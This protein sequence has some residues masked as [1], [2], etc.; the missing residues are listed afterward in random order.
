MSESIAKPSPLTSAQELKSFFNVFDERF[1]DYKKIPAYQAFVRDLMAGL[2]VALVAIP[3]GVGFSIASGMR[4]EQGIIAG[5]VAGIVGGLLG[6]SKY[7]VYGPTAAFITTIAGIVHTFDVPFLILSSFVAGFIVVL[8]GIFRLGR[9]FHFVPHSIIVGFT[10]GIAATIVASQLPDVLGALHKTSPH[11]LEKVGGLPD[12]FVDANGH[13]LFLGVLTFFI[14][15][16]IYKFSVFIP[17]P[18][19]A[20]AVCSF[21]ANN[22]WH[23]KFIPLVSTKY[24]SI[25]ENMFQLTLPSLGNH[26][27]LDLILPVLTITFIASIESLLSARMADRLANNDTPYHPN[28]ELFGQGVVNMV[29]PLLNGFPCTGALARTATS[30]KVGAVSPCASVL[31]GLSVIMLMIFFASQLNNIPM[32]CVGGLLL[33]V[34]KNM[35]KAEEVRGVFREGWVHIFLMFYTAL[36]TLLSDLFIAVFTATILYAIIQKV[37][38]KQTKE[39]AMSLS[40]VD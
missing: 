32:A 21:I 24:P 34:A 17:A 25:G 29:V 27:I 13:A 39:Q 15:H 28:K 20:L 36:V 23:D 16:Q 5:A 22:V 9:F 6:G 31:K 26:S 40:S 8:M 37:S 14:I 2:I 10:M 3:L 38:F 1:E 11:F 30:I 33:F 18:L 7:Q 35:V 19:I 4:P 12:L